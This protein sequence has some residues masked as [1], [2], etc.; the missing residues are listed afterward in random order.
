M[1]SGDPPAEA[2]FEVSPSNLAWVEDLYLAYLQE[3]TSVD[4]IW[5]RHFDQLARSDGAGNGQSGNGAAVSM[6]DAAAAR[7]SAAPAPVV[8]GITRATEA[9]V[10]LPRPPGSKRVRKLIEDFRA[11]GHLAADL[12]PLGLVDRSRNRLRLADYLVFDGDLDGEINTEDIAGADRRSLREIVSL[13]EETYAR[14]V[15]VELGHINDKVLRD[16]LQDRMEST[17]N[18]IKFSRA[19]QLHLLA[20]VTE[21]EVFELFLQTK[22]IGA[23]RF[24]LEGSESLI[25]LLDRVI[26]RAA[27]QGVS[28]IVIGMAHRGRLNVLA[29]VLGK[30]PA[31]IF[32]EFLDRAS[33]LFS[34]GGGDVKYHLGY[35]SDRVT[36][37]GRVHLSL[38]FNPSHLEWVDPVVMGR[39]RAKQDR[40]GDRKRERSLGILI[41]GDAAFAGQGVVAESLNMSGL[42]AYTTG[43]TIHVIVNNQIGF[44][45]GP[46][47][48]YCTTYPTDV[49]RMLQVPIFH[50]NGED[51][52]AIACAVDLAVDFRQSFARDVFIDMWCY[53]KLGHNEADEPAYT[54][55]VMYRAI[56]RKQSPRFS[57]L[58]AFAAVSNGEAAVSIAD[59]EALAASQRQALEQSLESARK[60]N[61]T[62]KPST[63]AGVWSRVQGGP[64]SMV[65]D[66]PTAVR[67]EDLAVVG[68]A[69]TT[70]PPDFVPHPKAAKLLEERAAMMTGAKLLDW[71]MGESLAFGTLLCQGVR[72]RVSG[73]DVR[74]GTFSHRHATLSDYNTGA[75]HTSLEHIAVG[76]GAFEI[77]DSC[78][79]EAGVLGFEYGYSLDMPEGL[80]VWEAQFGDFVNGAQVIIDQFLVSSEAKWRR[81][82]GLVL[83]L[84]HGMEGQGPEHSS[85]RLER[86]LNMCVNDNIQVVFPTTPAQMFHLLRRQVL[87]PYRKPLIVMSP[88][89]LLRNKLSTLAELTSGS[90]R[91]IILDESGLDPKAVER[92]ILCSGKVYYDLHAAREA[93]GLRNAAIIRVEQLYPLRREDILDALSEYRE[94]IQLIWT[95]EETRNMGAWLYMKRELR[96][97]LA[98][99]F[100]WSGISRPQSA[101]PATGSSTRHYVE[102]AKILEDALGLPAGSIQIE[103]GQI[104]F[105]GGSAS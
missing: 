48:S 40:L 42:D 2:A 74:R 17:H 80:V 87:R 63:F 67:P 54:Q 62:S 71:G 96:P 88:K 91:P 11:L 33:D 75:E 66:V 1:T 24:S 59:A 44:T 99:I 86:F 29:N 93:A 105:V 79:S 85:A 64:E 39:V 92:V 35:S 9:A 3:P 47:H 46:K 38:G 101:S 77:R 27:H 45:T 5:R 53:R 95:Q 26:E 16:W 69:L 19:E 51:P 20:K 49:A 25:P 100:R 58:A 90:F 68:K 12:D 82:S 73:Q 34:E 76:Q 81:V 21:A 8:S 103:K 56:A 72:V 65:Q 98:G 10:S 6:K 37:G 18:R 102:Q 89:S 41:H 36:P 30:P 31:E 60:F 104:K 14:H 7:A 50:V 70:L 83:L 4:E 61:T 28:Q 43:G 32:A 94:G 15:G 23:K 78:L 22:F 52:E 97:L 13:L 57:Y 55:P 84:P